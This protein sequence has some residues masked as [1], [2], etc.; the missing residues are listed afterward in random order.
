MSAH[1]VNDAEIEFCNSCNT[2]HYVGEHTMPDTENFIAKCHNLAFQTTHIDVDTG[3]EI[4]QSHCDAK[5]A[6]EFVRT[7]RRNAIPAWHVVDGREDTSI[8]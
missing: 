7:M 1:Y 5:T 4:T 3:N 8:Y 2:T 6:S